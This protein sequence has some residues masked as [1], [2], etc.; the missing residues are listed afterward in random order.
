MP[1]AWLNGDPRHAINTLLGSLKGLLRMQVMPK[2]AEGT[3]VEDRART[4]VLA[5]ACVYLA[6]R[7][8][9]VTRSV[10]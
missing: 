8:E 10:L 1:G 4:A 3:S 2:A 7:R 5:M 6:A 9:S